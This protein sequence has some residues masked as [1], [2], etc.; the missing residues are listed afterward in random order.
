MAL[1]Y[2]TGGAKSG[3]S[4][5]A[6]DLLLNMNNGNQ[7]NIY[8]ATSLI[9]DEEM[10]IKVSLHKKRR[11]DRWITVEGY[12]NFY[13]SLEKKFVEIYSKKKEIYEKD[14]FINNMLVDCLTNMISNII[15]ENID[16]EWSNPAKDQIEKCDE[17][18]EK[19]VEKLIEISQKF[20][21]VIIVSNE[22]G[23]GI[24]P[25]YPLG[26][27]FREIAGKMNQKIAE[28]ADEVFFVVSGIPIK[29]K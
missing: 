7:K 13:E 3:K 29:I 25:S 16:I 10:D 9:Y 12:K 19:E 2:V 4:K 15:F 20:E 1:I 17:V 8:L 24:V 6:E 26:R 11:Q 21:N 28:I 23:M 18:I 22:L 5:F 14:I 27:Y